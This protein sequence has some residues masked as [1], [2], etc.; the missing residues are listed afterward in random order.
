MSECAGLSGA[1][2]EFQLILR[3]IEEMRRRGFVGSMTVNCSPSGR[4]QFEFKGT[5]KPG[6]DDPPILPRQRKE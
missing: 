3:K 4:V 2:T 5:W 6:E 1:D